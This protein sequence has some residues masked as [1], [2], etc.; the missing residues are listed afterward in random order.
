MINPVFH[1]MASRCR[2]V[3]VCKPART[4]ALE[5][6]DGKLML[7][8]MEVLDTLDYGAL[9]AAAGGA[10]CVSINSPSGTRV[11]SVDADA[12]A[13]GAPIFS[14]KPRRAAAGRIR[15]NNPMNGI[16]AT[17]G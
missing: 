7:Q 1:E 14:P 2:T 12:G 5:F 17:R 11:C 16:S 6:D 10:E 13:G 15:V 8:Q 3:P 9:E 4:D